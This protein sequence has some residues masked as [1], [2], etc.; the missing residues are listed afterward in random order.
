MDEDLSIGEP[1]NRL[2][3]NENGVQ[4]LLNFLDAQG[5][6]ATDSDRYR[7][8]RMTT[9]WLTTASETNMA[10]WL[11]FRN[12]LVFPSGDDYLETAVREGNPPQTIY[13]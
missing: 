6:V 10:P 8:T 4:M 7:N 1:A 12:E 13:G 9:K 3:A 2:S 5:N 11:T